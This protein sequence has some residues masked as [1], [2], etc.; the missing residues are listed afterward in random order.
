MRLPL[1]VMLYYLRDLAP[2]T[3]AGSPY[4][5]YIENFQL[6]SGSLSDCRRNICY[7]CG[8]DVMPEAL[9]GTGGTVFFCIGKTPGKIA[10]KADHNGDKGDGNEKNVIVVFGKDTTLTELLNRMIGC[11]TSLVQW[12]K[13]CHRKIIEG[14]SLQEL[15]QMFAGICSFCAAVFQPDFRLIGYT[16]IREDAPEEFQKLIR[17]GR[18]PDSIMPEISRQQIP[19]RLKNTEH[20][21]YMPS[22]E[23]PSFYYIYRK[24][25]KNREVIAY[26][27]IFCPLAGPDEEFLELAELFL[28]NIDFYFKNNEKY[29][30]LGGY[31]YEGL[32]EKFLSDRHQT[33]N[34]DILSQMQ[35]LGM[36]VNGDFLL[37]QIALE[38]STS[39]HLTYIRKLLYDSCP[40]GKPFIF[41]DSLYMLCILDEKG[42]E[43]E[44][45]KAL[46][47]IIEGIQEALYRYS[48]I[49]L[50]SNPFS[51]M[52]AIYDA[53]KQCGFLHTILPALKKDGTKSYAYEDYTMYHLFSALEAHMDLSA[54][55]PPAFVR[56]QKS[57]GRDARILRVYL[58]ENLSFRKCAEA[59]NIHRNTA[60]Y[61]IRKIEKTLDL[62]FSDPNIRRQFL[63]AFQIMDYLD[64]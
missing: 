51:Y 62:D 7:I 24:H 29:D 35:A 22:A 37:I 42:T 59:L 48:C 18:T 9:D 27:C 60:E 54:A 43:K 16:D 26:S 13:E 21:I 20:A 61:Q 11:Y 5:K 15:M 10:D 56:F 58:E 34:A 49:C 32:L 30:R 47:R 14:C 57:C 33:L 17:L 41:S 28:Q 1:A 64:R 12:D 44:R 25:R 19:R 50:I 45:K 2:I 31:M 6:L 46:S 53:R 40:F 8:E 52:P 36:P 3:A 23:N 39:S 55:L 4:G 38:D 63:L